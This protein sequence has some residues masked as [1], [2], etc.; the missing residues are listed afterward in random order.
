MRLSPRRHGFSYV[1]LLVSTTIIGILYLIYLGPG[2]RGHEMKAKAEC[3]QRMAQLH[4]SLAMYA[5]DH[6]G[7]FP[8]VAGATSAD[9]PL[10]L[11]VPQYTA[12]TSLFI[13]PA[14]VP[15]ALPAAMP[16]A[17]RRISYAYYMGVKT[18]P[19]DATT[20]LLTDSQ[21][22]TAPRLSGDRLFAEKHV[23][24]G[25]NHRRFGGNVLFAD[26]H[27]EPMET[28]ASRSLV[29]APGVTLLNPLP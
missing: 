1:E 6:E 27:V 3:A 26:G 20:P 24:P 28:T 29:P 8:A 2:S 25:G 12:D 17:G 10:D 4:L 16:I 23:A 7:A 15:S 11:L 13:C 18:G 14:G 9:G 19:D 5:Q 21:I 22:D